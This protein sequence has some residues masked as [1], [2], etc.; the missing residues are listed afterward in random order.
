MSEAD[1]ILEVM[2]QEL[3]AFR[4]TRRPI[5]LLHAARALEDLKSVVK[6]EIPPDGS[7]LDPATGHDELT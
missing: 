2:A 6:T 7:R 1:S 4:E 5:H 3:E